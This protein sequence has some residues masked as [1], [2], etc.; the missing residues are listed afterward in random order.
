M[1]LDDKYELMGLIIFTYSYLVSS[2][3]CLILLEGWSGKLHASDA[4]RVH[5]IVHVFG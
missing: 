2:A 5:D 3:A 4:A 1:R